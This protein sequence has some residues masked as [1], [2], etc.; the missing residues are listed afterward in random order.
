MKEIFCRNGKLE[1]AK[2]TQ[3][4]VGAK[5][6]FEAPTSLTDLDNYQKYHQVENTVIS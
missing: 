1:N 5:I 3:D 2:Q 4:I 6:R